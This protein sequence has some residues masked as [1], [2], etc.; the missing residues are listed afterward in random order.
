M[1]SL[2]NILYVNQSEKIVFKLCMFF[3]NNI[4]S[5]IKLN[6]FHFSGSSSSGASSSGGFG[7]SGFGDASGGFGSSSGGRYG[8]F[9][10]ISI[11]YIFPYF[12]Y[13]LEHSIFKKSIRY[14]FVTSLIVACTL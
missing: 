3:K 14:C 1:I 10:V 11:N 7:G 12:L 2:F 9:I 13:K 8:S 6:A 4:L 5:I